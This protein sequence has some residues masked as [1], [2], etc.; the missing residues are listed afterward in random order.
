M[1][2]KLGPG[3]ALAAGF[4]G[5]M[6][7]CLALVTAFDATT[8]LPNPDTPILW[9]QLIY[10]ILVAVAALLW[11]RA[12]TRDTELTWHGQWLGQSRFS[13]AVGGASGALVL[14]GGCGMAIQSFLNWRFSYDREDLAAAIVGALLALSGVCFFLLSLRER[15]QSALSL[16]PGFAVCFWLIL[17]YHT[18]ARDPV[19]F[20]YAFLLLALMAAA[21]ALYYQAC[22]CFARPKPSRTVGFTLIAAVFC[23]QVMPAADDL[24]ARLVLAGL[25]V[26]MCQRLAFL[27]SEPGTDPENEST[28]GE[29]K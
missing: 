27:L 18:N 2:N 1:R 3:L 22:L 28:E 13:A 15:R 26:W 8:H 12:L 7:Q 14:V 17:F 10:C 29:S 23:L 20:H 6:M 11:G 21:V 19:V 5:A 25:G 16:L 4:A 9:V 24:G